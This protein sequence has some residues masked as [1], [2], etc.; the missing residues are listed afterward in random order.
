[1]NLGS[2]AIWP[3]GTTR[4]GSYYYAQWSGDVEQ[5]AVADLRTGKPSETLVGTN[6]SWSP[7]GKL[8]AF[9]RH[10][11]GSE[12]GATNDFD[13]VVH[14]LESGDEKTFSPA[15]G[16]VGTGQPA[17]LHNNRGLLTRLRASGS[18]AGEYRVDLEPSEWK[19]FSQMY[20]AVTV[21][22]PD[23]QTRYSLHRDSIVATDSVT[24]T[25]RQI[26]AVPHLVSGDSATLALSPDGRTLAFWSMDQPGGQAR[27]N[28]VGVDGT[29]F[30]EVRRFED[31]RNVSNS[32][33]AWNPDGQAIFVALKS[34]DK[35]RIVRIPTKGSQP[36]FTGI[37]TTARI[38]AFSLNPEG[39]KIVY[40]SA[41]D[42]KDAVR[43]FDN[44]VSS[45]K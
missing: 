33:L 5:I 31:A 17:W 30:R 43:A 20:L 35:W 39:S 18:S 41:K 40:S 14:S 26:Y 19:Q 37:E 38:Q 7:D 16:A 27:L 42:Q 15:F 28:T 8:I 29:N 25:E 21:L 23:D 44:V 3:I 11:P 13:L 10:R 2:G 32:A 45:L 1:L 34:D 9:K 36:E 24:D 6:P 12:R 4:S 22:S